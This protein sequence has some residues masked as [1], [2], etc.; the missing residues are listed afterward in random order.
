MLLVLL[1]LLPTQPLPDCATLPNPVYLQVGDTQEPVMKAL[2]R[3]LRDS[4][5]TPMTIVYQT[6]GSCTNIDAIFNSTKLSTNPKFVPSTAEDP[7][8][9]TSMPPLQCQ[10]PAGGVE[11][12]AVNSAVGLEVCTSSVVPAGIKAF[13][14]AI[15]PYVFVVPTASGENAITAEEAYFVFGFGM[16]GQAQPWTDESLYF[17][18]TP[19]KSTLLSLA[20]NIHVPGAKWKGMRFDKSADVVNAVT[21]SPT[22]GKTI[23]ILGAEIYDRNRATM[24]ALAFRAYDQKYAYFPDSTAG[25]KDKRNTRDGHYVAWSP[26]IYLTRVDANQKPVSPNVALLVDILTSKP[27]QNSA[28][29]PDFDALKVLI[30]QGLVPD[31]AMKVSREREGGD[32]SLYE[33]PNPCHCYFESVVDRPGSGCT[34]CAD[35][36]PCGAG[37]CRYGF[38]EAR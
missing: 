7:N 30:Q 26:T 24:K 23:G 1:S 17:I 10:V 28:S 19:T 27:Q 5:A 14:A 8:W 34:A 13:P 21:M 15:Q 32:L 12:D 25:S 3:K 33:A 22:P 16:E 31:C 38:C 37:K 29:L 11:L 20:A 36:G 4:A 2:G 6:S 18:R 9:T 35:D